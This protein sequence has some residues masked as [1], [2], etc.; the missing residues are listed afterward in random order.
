MAKPLKDALAAIGLT[1]DDLYG[2]PQHRSQ[3]S[4]FLCGKSPRHAMVTLGTEWGREMI[5]A[6]FWVNAVQEQI[7]ALRA[8]NETLPRAKRTNG[9]VIEDIR[10]PNEWDML[11]RLGGAIWRVRRPEVETLPHPLD[12]WRIEGNRWQSALASFLTKTGLFGK[13]VHVSEYW[14][15]QAPADAEF[16]NDGEIEDLQRQVTAFLARTA[17]R[18]T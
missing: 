12:R 5:G 11:A 1:K 2:P 17:T 7:I 8:K 16:I 3:P 14:W 6:D 9:V 13:P 15:S 4:S 18:N 10:F